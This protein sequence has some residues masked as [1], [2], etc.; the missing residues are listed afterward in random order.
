MA[1]GST[2]SGA[3]SHEEVVSILVVSRRTSTYMV[4]IMTNRVKR[5]ATVTLPITTVMMS[6]MLSRIC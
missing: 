3:G 2:G 5:R 4:R 1:Y 6:T